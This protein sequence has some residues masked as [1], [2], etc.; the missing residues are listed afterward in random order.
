MSIIDRIRRIAQANIH[1][2]LDKVDTPEMVLQ[3]KIEELENTIGDAKEALAGY[4]VSLKRLEMEQAQSERAVLEWMRKAETDL[5]K[6]RES[7]A[8]NALKHRIHSRQRVQRLETMSAQSRGIYEELKENLVV[9]NDQLR[10]AKLSLSE[11]QT[12]KKAALAQQS[13][14]G[15][16][17][18]AMTVSGRDINFSSFE[19]E[20]LQKE[21]EVEIDREVRADMASIE[22]EIEEKTIESMVDSELEALKKKMGRQE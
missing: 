14:G 10:A 15:N 13:F 3:D 17:D 7:A 9:L 11:L 12:R 16:L 20:V 6:G 19:E 5:E 1:S 4:A 21:M 8:R 2:L 18:K 22:R